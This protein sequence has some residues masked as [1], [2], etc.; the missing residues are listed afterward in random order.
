[1]FWPSVDNLSQRRSNDEPCLGAWKA[2][3]QG[4]VIRHASPCSQRKLMSAM[5]GKLTLGQADAAMFG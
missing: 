2:V 5:G 1:M 3:R 4:S